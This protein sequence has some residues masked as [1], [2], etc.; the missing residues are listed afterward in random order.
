MH[1]S[2]FTSSPLV[3][4]LTSLP[5]GDLGCPTRAYRNLCPP[6]LACPPG[7]PAIGMEVGPG[8]ALRQVPEF[9]RGDMLPASGTPR[10][11]PS[12]LPGCPPL[13]APQRPPQTDQSRHLRQA[14]LFKVGHGV[15]RSLLPPPRQRALA[16]ASSLAEGSTADSEDSLLD[17]EGGPLV[18]GEECTEYDD[19]SSGLEATRASGRGSASEEAAGFL[20]S[21][22]PHGDQ[23]SSTRQ[24][25]ADQRQPSSSTPPSGGSPA[26]ALGAFQIPF[27]Q[28]LQYRGV[29]RDCSHCL[30]LHR[31]PGVRSCCHEWAG[32]DGQLV[33]MNALEMSGYQ[34]AGPLPECVASLVLFSPKKEKNQAGSFLPQKKK[35]TRLV[36]FSLLCS[37]RPGPSCDCSRSSLR[38]R[39]RCLL[40][41]STPDAG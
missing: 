8:S 6:S 31:S 11:A 19:T 20:P 1:A 5:K 21:D 27:L 30:V 29:R 33:H 17:A 2:L 13:A 28:I 36:L 32:D 41:G 9:T 10:V 37:S 24:K 14:A 3:S 39:P 18:G 4:S 25:Q 40:V 22:T 38:R 26:M 16:C 15:T 7:E 23:E 12:I 35:R 34:Q